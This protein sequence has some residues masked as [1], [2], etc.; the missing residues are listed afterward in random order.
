MR[1][2]A[3]GSVLH[4]TRDALGASIMTMGDLQTHMLQR[5]RA[6]LEDVDRGLKFRPDPVKQEFRV[7]LINAIAEVEG[8]QM[9][10]AA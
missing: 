9:D 4:T 1:R 10:A 7:F 8:K 5:L 3:D 6:T 2:L